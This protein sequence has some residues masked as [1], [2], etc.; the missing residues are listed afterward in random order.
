MTKFEFT[1][2]SIVFGVRDFFLPRVKILD[3]AKI[4]PG[5]TILDYGCGTGS[6]SFIAAERV[7]DKGMIYALDILPPAVKKVNGLA[8]KRRILNIKTINSGCNTGLEKNTIDTV[9]FF[10]TFH[11]CENRETIL[12]ELHR[13]FKADGVLYFSDHHMKE[14]EIISEITESGLFTLLKKGRKLHA[15]KKGGIKA[16]LRT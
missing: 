16:A 10:D 12:K 14:S 5:D 8:G 6:Y 3:E 15:F 13:V 4:N 7:G 11:M 2:M 1:I 9:L